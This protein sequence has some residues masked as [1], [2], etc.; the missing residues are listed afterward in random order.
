MYSRKD[1]RFIAEIIA[2]LPMD[3][4]PIAAVATHFCVALKAAN[5]SFDPVRFMKV[6]EQ[7]H[8]SKQGMKGNNR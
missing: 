4:V 6:C 3:A 1:Y 8:A 5:P 7:A 2:Y